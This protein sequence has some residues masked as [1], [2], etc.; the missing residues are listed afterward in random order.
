M[1]KKFQKHYRVVADL[2]VGRVYLVEAKIKG[3]LG[4]CG[5]LGEMA[6]KNGNDCINTKIQ[7]KE[8][9][10]LPLENGKCEYR[11]VSNDGSYESMGEID[12]SRIVETTLLED[13]TNKVK[14]FL[15]E[16]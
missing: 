8:I 10:L 2:K 6:A 9:L 12:S 7:T 14:G 13:V 11:Y 15:N 1:S 5:V 3:Y 4:I 16:C